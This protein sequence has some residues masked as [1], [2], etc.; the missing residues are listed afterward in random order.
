MHAGLLL[1]Q[2]WR[3]SIL[4]Y[5]AAVSI[6]MNVLLMAPPVLVVLLKARIPP[7]TQ[8]HYRHETAQEELRIGAGHAERSLVNLMHASSSILQRHILCCDLNFPMLPRIF[9]GSGQCNRKALAVKSKMVC[10]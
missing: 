3:A 8:I 5:S 4:V 2:R 10:L 1:V 9:R 6:K 7:I